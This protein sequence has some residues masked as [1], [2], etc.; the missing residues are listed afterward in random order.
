MVPPPPPGDR[1]EGAPRCTSPLFEAR[2]SHKD[3]GHGGGAPAQS[4]PGPWGISCC[5][6]LN[7]R[8]V[9]TEGV[10][11]SRDEVIT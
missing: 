5:G 4:L 2:Q 7:Y 6:G 9:E 1:R 3:G 8:R 11:H 10:Q